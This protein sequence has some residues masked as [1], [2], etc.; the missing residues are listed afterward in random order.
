MNR[1]LVKMSPLAVLTGLVLLAVAACAT[2]GGEG[3]MSE[4]ARAERFARGAKAWAE[5]C[6]RCHN[7]RSPK[8][9]N[10]EDWDVS[11]THMRIRANLPRD[12]AEDIKAFLKASN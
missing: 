8:E 9:L 1:R 11:V 4:A 7:L 6:Q 5:T 2:P 10:D 12:F 3:Q